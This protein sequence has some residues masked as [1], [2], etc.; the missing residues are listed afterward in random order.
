MAFMSHNRRSSA[1]QLAKQ[2]DHGRW[3]PSGDSPCRAEVSA[4]RL[5]APCARRPT[6]CGE[7]GDSPY[8]AAVS[9][10]RLG[11][12]VHEWPTRCGEA[13]DS[14]AV[15]CALP[16]GAPALPGWACANGQLGV[17]RRRT[18]RRQMGDSPWRARPGTA[19]RARRAGGP[20]R[21]RGAKAGSS[22]GVSSST[23][24]SRAPPC[25]ARRRCRRRWGAPAQPP[26]QVGLQQVLH[27]HGPLLADLGHRGAGRSQPRGGLG[28]PV[29]P[30][31][32]R[33]RTVV[34]RGRC[35]AGRRGRGGP[36]A[37]VRR[38]SRR[39][40][41]AAPAHGTPAA[42]P[43]PP[44]SA[45][46]WWPLRRSPHRAAPGR[47]RYPVRRRAGHGPPRAP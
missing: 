23:C 9:A 13:G 34:R 1:R 14:P 45:A 24:Q 38:T 46:R 5:G 22:R 44:P 6:R 18:R 32:H 31:R 30:A 33:R 12:R 41:A 15:W 17:G 29:G 8:R 4:L 27:R 19:G 20:R 35:G 21:Q 28:V 3:R 7:T 43:V 16:S 42:R 11:G 47:G 39:S 26:Q 37:P 25:A 2:G 40:A 10:L 36:P